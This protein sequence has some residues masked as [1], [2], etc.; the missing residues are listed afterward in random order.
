MPT[1]KLVLHPQH[2]RAPRACP[3]CNSGDFTWGELATVQVFRRKEGG[4]F[5]RP[6]PVNA[7]RCNGCGNILLYTPIPASQ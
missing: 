5:E 3:Y 7:R 1:Q 6:Q 2:I 4:V